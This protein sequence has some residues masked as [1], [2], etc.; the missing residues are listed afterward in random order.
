M[1]DGPIGHVGALIVDPRDHHVTHVLLEEGPLWGRKQVAIP[2]G[3]VRRLDA[4][5]SV[6]LSKEQIED[7]PPVELELPDAS[8]TQIA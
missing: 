3:V 1:L 5:T 7:L 4:G 2:I 8:I 6:G